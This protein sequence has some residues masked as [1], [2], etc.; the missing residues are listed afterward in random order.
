MQLLSW[1]WNRMPDQSTYRW[2][3]A[4]KVYVDEVEG[5]V[6]EYNKQGKQGQYSY[7]ARYR[8]RF[9]LPTGCDSERRRYLNDGWCQV[10]ILYTKDK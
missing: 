8:N 5:L 7:H 9:S 1:K 6:R 4:Y 10:P 3:M 2:G